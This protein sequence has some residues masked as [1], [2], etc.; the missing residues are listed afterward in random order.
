MLDIKRVREDYEGVK[1]AV[2][3]RGKGDFGIEEARDLDVK[4]RELLAEVEALKAKQNSAN[5]EIPKLKKEGLDTTEVF[6]RLKELSNRIKELDEQVSEVSNS[7]K[8]CLLGIPNTPYKDVPLGKDDGDNVDFAGWRSR[9]FDFESGSL[10]YWR[11][12]RY[13]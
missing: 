8:D 1:A 3:R 12:F 5:K 10:G 11:V 2:E 13:S 4:R 7:L 9:A 6:S